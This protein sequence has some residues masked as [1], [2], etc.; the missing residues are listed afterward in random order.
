LEA[1]EIRPGLVIPGSDLSATFS[2]ASGPGGQ[3]VNKVASRVTLRF[4]LETSTV[5]PEA[6]KDRLRRLARRRLNQSGELI[7]VSQRSRDQ[8]SN[9]EDCRNKLRELV[10]KALVPPRRRRPTVPSRTAVQRRLETKTHQ[11]TKK[12]HR[13]PIDPTREED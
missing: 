4:S 10:L 7:I 2:R 1:L 3:N 12:R 13:Q 9:L 5:L 6:V 8:P 11:A